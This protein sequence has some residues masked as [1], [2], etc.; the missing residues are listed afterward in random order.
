MCC[1]NYEQNT[2]EKIRKNLP[3][4]GCIVDTEYGSGEVISNSVVKEQVKVKIKSK[5]SN[6][7]FIKEVPIKEVKIISGSYEGNV[8]SV[9]KNEIEVD[10]EDKDVIRELLKED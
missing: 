7:D 1:L 2:Y 5:D 10:N 4:V 8:D 6:E 3:K 9:D